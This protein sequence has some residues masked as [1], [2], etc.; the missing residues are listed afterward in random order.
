MRYYDMAVNG[1]SG[2]PGRCRFEGEVKHDGELFYYVA[3]AEISKDN[4][5]GA[6]ADGNR[7]I[8]AYF[9]DDLHIH[10][11]LDESGNDATNKMSVCSYFIDKVEDDI[12]EHGEM[13]DY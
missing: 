1:Y 3:F 9:I 2:K 13:H 7:G 10:S 5:Y 8:V 12:Y 4:N 11:V 6:D